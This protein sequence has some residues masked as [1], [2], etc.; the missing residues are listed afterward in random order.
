MSDLVVEGE[1]LRGPAARDHEAVVGVGGRVGER[2]D[3]QAR[4]VGGR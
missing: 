3:R 2:V 1:V 4:Q